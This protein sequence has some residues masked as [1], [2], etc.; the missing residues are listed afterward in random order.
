MTAA[1]PAAGR[2][3]GLSAANTLCQILLHQGQLAAT[4]RAGERALTLAAG[5]A[6][7][8]LPALGSVYISIAQVHDARDE[9]EAAATAL[10]RGRELLAGTVEAGAAVRGA[11][12]AA[13]LQAAAGEVAGG[14]VA[15]DECEAWLA[16]VGWAR[17]V[18]LAVLAA[19]RALLQLQAGELAAAAAWASQQAPTGD[20]TVDFLQATAR[21]RVAL[22]QRRLDE[23]E[24]LL[25][26]L[27]PAWQAQRLELLALHAV[28]AQERGVREAALG[29]LAAALDLAA[30][31]GA[32]GP[33]RDAGPQLVSLLHEP[34]IQGGPHPAF[35]ARLLTIW[36][37]S[38]GATS[39]H[40][41]ASRPRHA[42]APLVEP[43]TARE[44]EVLGLIAEGLSNQAIADRLI[45]SLSTVKW[46][47]TTIYGKLGV[48]RRTEAV[49][50]ARS[51][52]L[53][54]S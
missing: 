5:W 35:V 45:I 22:A 52:G 2:Y 20:P 54:P 42:I 44:T 19:W 47:T 40:H 23:A 28:V 51:L 49:A 18:F 50:R 25:A 24:A 6:G 32:I 11:A 14:L 41:P 26:A 10:R 48:D 31:E 16:R 13:Q 7:P 38:T 36:S 8:A 9:R 46:Y 43:L 1:T 29:F 3:A 37:T 4:L 15:L 21:A 27:A 12:L 17:P 39:A 53:L 33:L 30:P 34:Q